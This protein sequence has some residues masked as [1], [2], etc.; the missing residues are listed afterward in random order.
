[1]TAPGAPRGG[2]REPDGGGLD[3]RAMRPREIAWRIFAHELTSSSLQE[4]GE[5]EKATTHVLTPLGARVSRLLMVGKLAQVERVGDASAPLWRGR[6]SDPTGGVSLTAGSYHPAAAAFLAQTS[7]PPHV[8]VIGKPHLF[9]GREGV[10]IVSIRAEALTGIGAQE[11]RAWIVETARQTLRRL[12][13]ARELASRS[14]TKAG[15]DE[16]RALP[17]YPQR[18]VASVASVI[19]RYPGSDPERFRA[20]VETALR[21]VIASAGP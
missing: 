19:G 15:P 2:S 12:T 3:V 20:P 6:L 18:L 5:G 17:G 9:V 1:M 10:P 8:A 7:L 13:L 16:E 4:R 21:A 11:E 14:S